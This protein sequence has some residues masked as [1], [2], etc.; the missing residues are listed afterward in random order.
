MDIKVEYEEGITKRHIL[1]AIKILHLFGDTNKDH[2]V[3]KEKILETIGLYLECY[4]SLTSPEV[5]EAQDH[6]NYFFELE[7][8]PKY[9]KMKADVE[10]DYKKY[11]GLTIQPC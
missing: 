6:G 4:G 5:W 10:H 9:A 2:T 8:D 1:Q 11:N 7:T 3:N